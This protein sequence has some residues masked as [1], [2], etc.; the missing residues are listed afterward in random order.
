MKN[1]KIISCN[2]KIE[3]V[4]NEKSE[5]T[6]SN[7][8]QGYR[9]EIEISNNKKALDELRLWLFQNLKFD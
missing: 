5:I 9:L 8:V 3:Q 1:V 7:V 4:R 6:N 2:T